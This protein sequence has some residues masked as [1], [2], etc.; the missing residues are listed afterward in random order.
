MHPFR[1]NLLPS[2]IVITITSGV[3]MEF[4]RRSIK[5]KPFVPGV[6][7]FLANM[8]RSIKG[9]CRRHENPVSTALV[10]RKAA[11]IVQSGERKLRMNANPSGHPVTESGQPEHPRIPYED[12]QFTKVANTNLPELMFSFGVAM[13]NAIITPRHILRRSVN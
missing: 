6:G 13:G 5:L 8:C 3:S 4:Q 2:C 9:G 1:D 7:G 10:R 12:I 11:P